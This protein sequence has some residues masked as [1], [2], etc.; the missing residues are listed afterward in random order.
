MV[1]AGM[2]NSRGRLAVLAVSALALAGAGCGE[3]RQDADAP[4][5]EFDVQVTDA[6]FPAK[7]RIAEPTTLKL[8]VA[9]RGDR[10]VPNLAVTV[11]TQPGEEGQAPAAFGQDEDNPTLADSKR[12]VWIVD[13][14]PAGGE[15]AYTN[16]W[17][18]GP[19]GQGQT[20]TVEWKVTAMQTG[21]YTVGWRLAPSLEG[22]VK[23]ADGRTNGEFVVTIADAPVPAR[24]DGD[25]D[26]VRGEEAGR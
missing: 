24:V 12:P 9:N 23:L 5:G 3:E 16:T 11:E 7:Q 20:R 13:E 18:V 22:D 21:R 19:L 4:S 26:V 10:A 15:S 1:A 17:A 25:G 14:G 8:E 2:G 6:S